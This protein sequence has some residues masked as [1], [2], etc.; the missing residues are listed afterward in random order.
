MAPAACADAASGAVASTGISR[1]CEYV[2]AS[3]RSP[4]AMLARL[5]PFCATRST[6]LGVDSGNFDQ[7]PSSGP[8][9]AL[10][11]NQTSWNVTNTCE[12]CEGVLPVS[13]TSVLAEQAASRMHNAGGATSAAERG[14]FMPFPERSM[15]MM[16]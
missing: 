1:T 5:A 10:V 9:V 3:I 12:Y 16:M 6:V 2:P 13:D 11:L 4:L 8:A 7:P 15:L 14:F